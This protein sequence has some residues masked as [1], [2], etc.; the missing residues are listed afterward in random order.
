M[1][2]CSSS[3][4]KANQRQPWLPASPRVYTQTYDSFQTVL[5][6]FKIDQAE[7]DRDIL[8]FAS[9]IKVRCTLP[10]IEARLR[11]AWKAARY[12]NPGLAVELGQHYKTYQV[13]SLEEVDIWLWTTFRVHQDSCARDVV[14]QFQ[15]AARPVLHWFP[16]TQELLLICHHFYSDAR[17][18]WHFWELLLDLAVEPEDVSFGEEGINLPLARDD[19]LGLPSYPTLPSFIKA[20]K[21]V[22]ESLKEDVVLLP[23]LKK[24]PDLNELATSGLCSD[25][26]GQVRMA[27]SEK[28]T[29]AMVAACQKRGVSVTAAFYAALALASQA[30]QAEHSSWGRYSLSFHHFDARPWYKQTTDPRGNLGFDHHAIIPFALDLQEKTYGELVTNADS[31]F[32]TTRE[33]FTRDA[34]GLDAI[35]YLLA[36]V[37][38]PRTPLPSAPFFSS[39]GVAEKYMK[40]FYGQKEGPW[41]EVEDL[42]NA[43]PMSDLVTGVFIWT[44]RGRFNVFAGFHELYHTAAMFEALMQ[45]TCERMLHGLEIEEEENLGIVCQE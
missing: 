30:L 2:A 17:G 37:M 22:A 16:R 27:L 15:H 28:Q 11:K 23:A 39:Y 33:D 36:S 25:R 40:T 24:V 31:F 19:L 35:N 7:S 45:D 5:K 34:S 32:K 41:L 12:H 18:A 4:F 6:N 10:D 8:P 43:V 21:I 9:Y 44:F 14:E 29:A 1:T 3:S 20:H 38:S 42:Y 26:Y 13:P